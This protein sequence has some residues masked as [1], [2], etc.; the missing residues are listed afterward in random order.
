MLFL[1]LVIYILSS[2]WMWYYGGSFSQR[3][4]IEYYIYFFIPFSMLL[5]KITF[6][7]MATFLIIFL[8]IVCQIQTYQYQR[9][10]IHWSEMNKER[11][12]NNFLRIDKVLK[13]SEKEW[14]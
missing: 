14:E 6:H 2:W 8:I 4:M 3:V 10:Y 7:K 5:Q 11:Y 12:W 9:G 13:N 1:F